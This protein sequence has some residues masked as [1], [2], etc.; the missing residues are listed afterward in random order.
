MLTERADL[1]RAAASDVQAYVAEGVE[2]SLAAHAALRSQIDLMVT[3]GTLIA[4]RL[5]LGGTV[6]AV[7][8][9]GSAA[10]AQHLVTELVGRFERERPGLRAVTLGAD[11]SVLTALG[12]DYGYVA[13]FRRQVEALGRPGDV[14]V[15]LS[16]SGQSPNILEAVEAARQQGML[17]VGLT[18]MVGGPLAAETD[19]CLCAD[20]PATPRVQEIHILAIHIFCGV[21]EQLL[22][23]DSAD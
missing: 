21:V 19:Y 20:S 3:I 16:T 4:D 15:A 23:G 1:R 17:T 22:F 14:L 18:G 2:A 6:F 10:Q 11:P 9:G 5:R 13:A 12:N 8:N 7:G